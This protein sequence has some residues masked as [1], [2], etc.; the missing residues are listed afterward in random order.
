MENIVI[1]KI[2]SGLERNKIFFETIFV[3]VVGF[4][5]IVFSVAQMRNANE[6]SKVAELEVRILKQGTYNVVAPITDYRSIVIPHY[7]EDLK[8]FSND[9]ITVTKWFE[10]TSER[11][12][13]QALFLVKK[14]TEVQLEK[15][16]DYH[17]VSIHKLNGNQYE[18]IE[19][20]LKNIFGEKVRSVSI[21]DSSLIQ[22]VRY[23]YLGHPKY[24]YG[25]Y[26]Y[27]SQSWETPPLYKLDY[28]ERLK[29]LNSLPEID[30]KDVLEVNLQKMASA[31]FK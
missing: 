7:G 26:K 30:M 10:D 17:S 3:A 25:E 6:Q 22:I 14:L 24:F 1:E 11:V 15:K 5:S 8:V 9:I 20:S 19:E 12:S 21:K 4:A 31:T 28:E 29:E 2:R 13:E 27:N 18:E 16:N 23:D